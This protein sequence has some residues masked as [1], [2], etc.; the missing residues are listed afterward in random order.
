MTSARALLMYVSTPVSARITHPVKNE[1]D[2]RRRELV[3]VRSR[4]L[5]TRAFP[6]SEMSFQATRQAGSA[7]A[8]RTSSR[9]DA[10]A[11]MSVRVR[12]VC[13]GKL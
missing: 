2:G 8:R 5:R 9:T 1:A 13:C 12:A 10:P 3:S 11:A 7:R 6:D 4:N